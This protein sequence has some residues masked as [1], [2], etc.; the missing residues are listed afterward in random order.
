MKRAVL[1][2]GL[3]WSSPPSRSTCWVDERAPPESRL[4]LTEILKGLAQDEG[5]P[6]D[7]SEPGES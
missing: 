3:S 4:L 6:R 1:S 7:A 2:H 5:D